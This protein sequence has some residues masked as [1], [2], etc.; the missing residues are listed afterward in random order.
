M[1]CSETISALWPINVCS[2]PPV[3][4]SNSRAVVS[5]LPEATKLPVGSKEMHTISVW[6]PLNVC[7]SAPVA[8]SHS[9]AVLSKEPV[10]MRSLGEG[11]TKKEKEKE[12]KKDMKKKEAEAEGRKGETAKQCHFC[13]PVRIV[14]G[15]GVDDVLVPF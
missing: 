12:A 14:E 9:L 5:M 2:E 3:S 7:S 13:S 8:V 10:T 4:T 6:W 15:D 1:K 11:S